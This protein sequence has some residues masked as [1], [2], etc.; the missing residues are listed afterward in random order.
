MLNKVILIGRLTA[1]V[2]VRKSAAG[3][4]IHSFSLA[5][6]SGVENEAYFFNVKVF[7]KLTGAT[8]LVHKGDKI[9]LEGRLVQSK[10]TRKDGS[11]ASSVEIIANSIE[12]IDV[13]TPVAPEAS[14]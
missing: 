11:K 12:F 8:K 6:D 9:A 4:E 1:D 14:K 10:F 5:V 13:K 3:E 7:G 2:E